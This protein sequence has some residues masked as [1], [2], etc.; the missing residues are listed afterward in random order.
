[1]AKL[2]NVEAVN[3]AL[4]QEMEADNSVVVL[5]E[6]VGVDGGVFRATAGL[7]EKYGAERVVDTPLAEMGII[8]AA[9][10]LAVNGLRPVAEMRFMG[11]SYLTKN[12][13]ISHASRLR[14]RTRGRLTC[15]LVMRMPYSG[16]VRALEH[17]SES[18]EALFAQVPG[19]KVVI[20]SNP[21][22]TKGLLVSAIR[23]P[24]PVVFLEAKKI[25]RSIKMDV[26]EESYTVPIGKAKVVRE[27]DDVTIIGYGAMMPVIEQVVAVLDKHKV[28]AE[29]IDLRTISPLDRWAVINSVRKTGRCGVVHEAPKSFGV[30]AE[31]TALINE[32][33]LLS[34]QAPVER[35]TGFDIVPPLAKLE[36]YYIPDVKRV[37]NSVSKVM[38]W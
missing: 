26:P 14:N 24:D 27:G 25:Y 22:D 31:L 12:H 17:H 32:H 23:D 28:S 4:N 33:A 7:I 34:L 6:D 37:L 10:G 20:P 30:A 3:L 16:G 21:Y 1:M 29:V 19:L 38:G 35:V 8:G 9:V 2:V 11:F 15:P 5:G 18:T 13:I 36:D